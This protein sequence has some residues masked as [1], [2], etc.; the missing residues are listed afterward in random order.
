MPYSRLRSIAD[1]GFLKVATRIFAEY[2]SVTSRDASRGSTISSSSPSWRNRRVVWYIT[3]PRRL[4]PLIL[5][6]ENVVKT[7]KDS[8]AAAAA[9]LGLRTVAVRTAA[10]LVLFVKDRQE[11]G[12]LRDPL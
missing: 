4:S 2:S 6:S 5:I 8:A 7:R 3:E 10:A 11:G 9:F 1:F 12:P